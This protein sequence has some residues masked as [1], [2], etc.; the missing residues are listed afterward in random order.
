[1]S[2][3]RV[4]ATKIPSPPRVLKGLFAVWFQRWYFARWAGG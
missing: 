1:M 2:L 3:M 4:G